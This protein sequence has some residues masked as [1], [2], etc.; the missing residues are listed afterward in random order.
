MRARVLQTGGAE[1]LAGISQPFALALA[2]QRTRREP[3]FGPFEGRIDEARL[4]R[5]LRDRLEKRGLSASA[6]QNFAICPHRFFLE[7]MLDLRAWQDPSE[8]ADIDDLTRG[9]LFHDAARRIAA[10]WKGRRFAELSGALEKSKVAQAAEESLGAFEEESGFSIAPS[11][12]RQTV[13]ARLEGQLRAWLEFERDEGP[14]RRPIGAEV[15]FGPRLADAGDEDEQLSTDEALDIAGIPVRGRIDLLSRDADGQLHVT[16]FKVSRT[17]KRADTIRT[18]R[19]K[20]DRLVFG[21]E[22]A[23]LPVYALA[24][25]GPIRAAKDLPAIGAAE[26]LYVAPA[27]AGGACEPISIRFDAAELLPAVKALGTFTKGA[28]EAVERGLFLP[29]TESHLYKKPCETCDF[30]EV[31]GPSHERLFERKRKS[32]PDPAVVALFAL[33]EVP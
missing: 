3:L 27:R 11:A 14:D 23:Q 2:R 29:K 9:R 31:C 28:L 22:L 12:L 15:R 18:G 21:G 6:L 13:R 32:D 7:R 30:A 1:L 8:R 16:D 19:E 33:R 10:A 24:C 20:R 26:F 25:Q 5:A 17:R 4:R